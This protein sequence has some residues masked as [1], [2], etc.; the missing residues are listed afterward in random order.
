ML[1]SLITKCITLC[2]GQTW[3]LFLLIEPEVNNP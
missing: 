1:V 3:G 2:A